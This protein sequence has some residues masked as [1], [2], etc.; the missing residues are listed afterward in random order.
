MS[1][2]TG[3]SACCSLC[4]QLRW[5]HLCAYICISPGHTALLL[6]EPA[7]GEAAVTSIG[8]TGLKR[9]T[10]RPQRMPEAGTYTNSLKSHSAVFLISGEKRKAGFP[11]GEALPIIL[12]RIFI[13]SRIHI[14]FLSPICLVKTSHLSFPALSKILTIGSLPGTQVLIKT[15]VRGHKLLLAV[16]IFHS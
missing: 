1:G 10:H 11:F 8:S 2:V 9:R 13:Q 7:H 16:Q 5:S 14:F 15:S 3:S 12:N 6:A 4:S